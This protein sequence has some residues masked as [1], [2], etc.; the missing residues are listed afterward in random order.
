MKLTIEEVRRDTR[1][2]CL[3]DESKAVI[4][5]A[6]DVAEACS[7][8]AVSSEPDTDTMLN[9]ADAFAAAITP[10]GGKEEER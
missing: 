6:L 8:W 10:S 1:T 4:Y 9:K 7:E 2:S 3:S 5:A